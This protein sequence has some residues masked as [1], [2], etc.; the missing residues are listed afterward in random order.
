MNIILG[1]TA[2]FCYGVERAIKG[3]KDEID[4]QKEV[5]CLG[6]IVHNKNVIE[7]L[8]KK[9]IKF[10]DNIEDAKNDVIIRAH[11]VSKEIYEKAEKMQLKIKDLTCPHVLKIHDIVDEYAKKGYFIFLVGK[12]DHPEIIGTNS[13]GGK[14][15]TIISDKSEIENSINLL[16]NTNIKKLLIVSQTTYSSKK[17]DE[18]VEVLNEKISKDINI[19]IKKTICPATEIRQK[20]TED[21]AKKVDMMI[22]IGDK[23][24][25]NTNKLYNISYKYC[26]K[27]LFIQDKE[28]LNINELKNVKKIGIMA[29]A[30]TPKEDIINIEK[31]LR[32]RND[33][34]YE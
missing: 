1:K 4:K 12:K 29:G 2:G 11:G 19:T 8:K 34:K 21:I 6:E 26:N 20:E 23:K 10:I 27:V 18:L 33:N 14:N 30:S 24:S 7:D 9:G 13:F 3:A 31:I 22:I 28:E 17:F 32:E 25:S 5:Y 15:I 16:Y